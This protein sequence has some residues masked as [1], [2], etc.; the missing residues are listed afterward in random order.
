MKKIIFDVI[1]NKL[2]KWKD[3]ELKWDNIEIEKINS[4]PLQYLSKDYFLDNFSDNILIYKKLFLFLKKWYL[5]RLNNFY[6]QKQLA[7]TKLK[8]NYNTNL[9]KAEISYNENLKKLNIT[10]NTKINT[11]K[12]KF[13]EKLQKFINTWIQRRQPKNQQEIINKRQELMVEYQE[14]FKDWVR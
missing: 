7:K 6:F 12:Q 8:V 13:N 9:K 4:S 2:D 3:V 5:L 1:N 14:K 10:Y 11:A